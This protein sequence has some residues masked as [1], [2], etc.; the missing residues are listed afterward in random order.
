MWSYSGRG[1][2]KLLLYTGIGS[3]CFIMQI[4]T[5]PRDRCFSTVR[6]TEGARNKSSVGCCTSLLSP[7]SREPEV[8]D[9]EES[10]G[11]RSDLCSL[12]LS[13]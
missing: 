11:T 9:R 6:G 7:D 3:N 13:S 8:E 12:R 2:S 1:G 5:V 4:A 10:Q